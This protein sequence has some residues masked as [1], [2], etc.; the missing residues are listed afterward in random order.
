MAPSYAARPHIPPARTGLSAIP[1]ADVR[2][3]H[4]LVVAHI[5]RLRT[6]PELR[7]CTV[8]LVLES[9]LAFEAQHLMHALNANNVKRW[10][11]LSEGA[12]GTVGWLTVNCHQTLALT[13]RSV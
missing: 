5:Q 2:E 10:V 13:T 12:S 6:I 4:K 3:T 11:A 1:R 8:V 9:N 7:D